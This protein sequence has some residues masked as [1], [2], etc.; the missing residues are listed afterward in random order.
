MPRHSG[1]AEPRPEQAIERGRRASAQQV[2]ENDGAGLLPGKPFELRGHS[3]AD[4]SQAFRLVVGLVDDGAVPVSRSR[5]FGDHDDGEPR[6]ARLAAGDHLGHWLKDERD[7][8]DQ[9]E[10]GAGRDARV[11]RDPTGVTPHHLHDEHPTV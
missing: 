5:P 1:R 10:V 7:L 11:E 3:A 4:A 2:P 9:N 6:T 8:G